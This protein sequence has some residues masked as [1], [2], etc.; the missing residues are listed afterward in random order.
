MKRRAFSGLGEVRYVN[1][2]NIEIESRWAEGQYDRLPAMAADLI[3]RRV[4][5]RG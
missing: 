1:G 5:V 4:T 3:D 2:K